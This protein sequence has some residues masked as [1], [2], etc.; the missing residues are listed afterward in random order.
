MKK[1]MV[2]IGA[3]LAAGCA[4]NAP[5]PLTMKNPA[6]AYCVEQGGK[7]E[8]VTTSKGQTGYCT[9]PSGERIDEWTLYRRD[10]QQSRAE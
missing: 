9:L 8:I 4:Q 6:A 1:N 5:A 7:S 3:L 10:H 2:F